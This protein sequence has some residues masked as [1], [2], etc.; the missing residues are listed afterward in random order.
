MFLTRATFIAETERHTVDEYY[1]TWSMPFGSCAIAVM[2]A[3]TLYSKRHRTSTC[4]DQSKDR[5]EKTEI[6]LGLKQ[7]YFL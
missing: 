2:P 6:I 5:A 1:L 7:L 3:S 4:S